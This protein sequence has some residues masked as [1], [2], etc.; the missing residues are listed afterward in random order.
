MEANREILI[1]LG[2]D[3]LLLPFISSF[4]D[5]KVGGLCFL[6]EKIIDILLVTAKI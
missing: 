1:L 3:T 2:C 6:G 5:L 4:Q